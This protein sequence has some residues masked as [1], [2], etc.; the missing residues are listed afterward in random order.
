MVQYR[1]KNF[2]SLED[3]KTMCEI[4]KKNYKVNNQV[5]FE[6]CKS[7][8]DK[9]PRIYTA[10]THNSKVIGYINFMPITEECYNN[11][12]TGKLLEQGITADDI[13][14]MEPNNSYYC[15]FSSVV[16]DKAYQNTEAFTYLIS[17]FYKN[18]LRF[19][20]ENNIKITSIIADCVNNKIE[21]F[22]L[23]S[24]FKKVLKN[25]NYKIYEGNIFN[26]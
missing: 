22:V 1:I 8:Y 15:L 24:G 10:I 16:V 18:M 26:K 19:T 2:V 23:N 21:Q 3:V 6:T 5:D 4:D 14:I 11:F 12:K 25:K 9:N 20:T 17:S 7:W 13:L